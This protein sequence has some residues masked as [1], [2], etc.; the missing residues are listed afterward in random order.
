MMRFA[1]IIMIMIA[2]FIG[3]E[4]EE[5]EVEDCAGIIGGENICG[6]TD[7][8]SANFD[9]TATFDDGSCDTSHILIPGRSI[10]IAGSSLSLIHNSEPTRPY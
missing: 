10:Y 9:S 5:N 8:T 1:L 7:S 3:C 2:F 6:C 4:K